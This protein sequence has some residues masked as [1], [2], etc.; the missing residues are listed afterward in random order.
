[1]TTTTT[2][3]SRLR[4][5]SET[6]RRRAVRAR[7][8]ALWVALNHYLTKPMQ[9]MQY[10]CSACRFLGC[11]RCASGC[12]FCTV[13]RLPG[14]VSGHPLGGLKRPGFGAGLTPRVIR[15]RS[16]GARYADG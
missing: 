14:T 15:P 9:V 16:G 12:A 1:M 5:A 13:A 7:F 8:G 6:D 2:T 10:Q 3:L 11:E 4:A